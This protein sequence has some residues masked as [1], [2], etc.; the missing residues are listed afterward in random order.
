MCVV[1]VCVGA[2]VTWTSTS[3]GDRLFC[4]SDECSHSEQTSG[5]TSSV[6]TF[7]GADGT[8][9]MT[10]VQ[11][12]VWYSRTHQDNFVAPEGQAPP[13]STYVKM[14][15]NG[16]ALVNPGDTM[17]EPAN[18]DTTENNENNTRHPHHDTMASPPHRDASRTGSGTRTTTLPLSIYLNNATHH[19]FTA[20]TESD[21][22]WARANGYTL[23][24][25]NMAY[26]CVEAGCG[27]APANTSDPTIVWRQ[28]GA[29]LEE[30][31]TEQAAAAAGWQ[32]VV[33]LPPP[34]PPSPDS[35]RTILGAPPPPPPSSL[36]TTV[37]NGNLAARVYSNGSVLLDRVSDGT[38][39]LQTDAS[40]DSLPSTV[41]GDGNA[42][43]AAAFWDMHLNL[44]TGQRGR[45]FGLGQLEG[46]T[47][48]GGCPVDGKQ[49]G[50]PLARNN[51]TYSLS[52]TKFHVSVPFVTSSVGY[53]VLVNHPGAG[54]VSVD[55]AGSSTWD[56]SEQKQLDVWIA[57]HANDT[58][59]TTGP[60]AQQQL[61]TRYVD[62]TGH[63][64]A[65]P[66]SA[67]QFW[68]SRLRYRTSQEAE[69]VAQRMGDRN[70]SAGVFVIDFFNQRVNGDFE[71]NPVCYPNVSE[72]V[73]SV[74]DAVGAD[75]MVSLWPDVHPT[76]YSH[77]TLANAN[78]LVNGG[79]DATAASCRHLIW[80]KYV[81]PNYWD[82][83]VKSFWLDETDFMK[84]PLSCGPANYCG[85]LWLNTWMQLFADGTRNESGQALILTRGWW[86]GAQRHGGVLWS[87]DIF[88]TF[89]E[90]TAQVPEAIAAGLSGIPYWSSDT[91]GFGCPTSPHADNSTYMQELIVRW[92]QFSTLCPIM[93]THGC[94]NGT[95]PAIPT[96]PPAACLQ[97][98][99]P[100]GSCGENE[101]WSFG[102]ATEVILTKYIK[103]R[104]EVIAPYMLELAHNV[105]AFGAVTMRSLEFEF[106]EDVNTHGVQ[107]EFLLG[108]RYLVA[109]VTTH[110]AI[111]RSVYFPLGVKWTNFWDPTDV[112][113]GGQRR[114][115][116]APL[117]VL[118]LYIRT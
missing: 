19:S 46:T 52:T 23:W 7:Y 41:S 100:G 71:M 102:P 5:Y 56:L 61:H 58:V 44:S 106:P 57:T 118:P 105:S 72:L 50:L 62:A 67:M 59:T 36:L 21:T 83:G 112:V 17:T 40:F 97:G 93:R 32:G 29:I 31:T 111:N 33:S 95:A 9:G 6:D 103:L 65:L 88:S 63:A 37:R 2:A 69:S 104:N 20:A 3:R 114:T 75:L 43:T 35:G 34:P 80:T 66:D 79:V 91:G 27:T 60:D 18:V 74:H 85:R 117:D 113:E 64:S 70:L 45:V 38:V 28:P 10:T 22:A 47:S 101:V 98:Q 94:R 30:C 25:A 39:L 116:D 110:G 84:G 86:P 87:S 78:C 90:L 99:G 81:K 53:A 1:C 89:S 108:P 16:L 107:D 54:T 42:T 96:N 12:W 14:F 13:D 4:L 55:E 115:V 26:L 51:G 82:Y 73:T 49:V 48:T 77:S 15:P 109:P 76:S 8:Q 24:R 68:Q 11:L 92:Y